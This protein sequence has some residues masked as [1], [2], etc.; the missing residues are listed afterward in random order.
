MLQVQGRTYTEISKARVAA[1]VGIALDSKC[2]VRALPPKHTSIQESRVWPLSS[3]L[4]APC[5]TPL[6][7]ARDL[8]QLTLE[9]T[10]PALIICILNEFILKSWGRPYT[11]NG[12]TVAKHVSASVKR[13]EHGDHRGSAHWFTIYAVKYGTGASVPCPILSVDV[14][15]SIPLCEK[16]E[17]EDSE[18]VLKDH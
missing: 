1:D 18:N 12:S 3:L 6:P 11:A 4:A 5:T 9:N 13:E 2:G 17:F 10:R 16:G 14:E 7:F 8:R 15:M